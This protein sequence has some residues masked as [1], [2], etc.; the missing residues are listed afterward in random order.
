M[1]AMLSARSRAALHLGR[2][3]AT[4]RARHVERQQLA[5][6]DHR[7]LRDIG[8]TVADVRSEIGKPFWRS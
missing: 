3:I 5:A 8:P 4:W 6:M 2:L 7:A 1:P